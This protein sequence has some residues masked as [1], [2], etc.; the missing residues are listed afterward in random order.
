MKIIIATPLYPPDIA[1][2][3]PYV[4]ELA[5]RLKEKHEITVVIYGHLPEKVPGVSFVCV[6]K[7]HPLP[8][9]LL[10][11]SFALWKAVRDADM[12]YC[13]NGASVEL[14][15][16]L[17]TLFT[18]RPL[19]VHIGDPIARKN[20]EKNYLLKY[21]ERFAARRAREVINETPT[22]RPEI[23]PLD[24]TPQAELD[25]YEKSWNTH[26]NTLENIFKY[27]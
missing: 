15:A 8:L 14:P 4:K 24:P 18:R 20:A 3:A 23:I 6:D 10:R 22:P 19:I 21:I 12:L 1:S 27:V 9:R 11:F 7:R 2:P 5:K 13:E 26:I 17:V 25:A 16:G